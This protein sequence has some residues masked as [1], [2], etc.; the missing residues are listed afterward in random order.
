MGLNLLKNRMPLPFR[1][2]FFV[3]INLEKLSTFKYNTSSPNSEWLRRKKYS[4]YFLPHYIR[5]LSESTSTFT[6]LNFFTQTLSG[7]KN[8]K[9]TLQL[10][11][12]FKLLLFLR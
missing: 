11:I 4:G 12:I 2:H 3:Y 8:R 10:T 5:D 1:V 6:R 7:G 9:T